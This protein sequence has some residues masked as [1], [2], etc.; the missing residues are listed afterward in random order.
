MA[1][2]SL[3]LVTASGILLTGVVAL[4]KVA[5]S[6]DGEGEFIAPAEIRA[7]KDAPGMRTKA[8]GDGSWA[9]IFSA[10][11]EV[12][13]GLTQWAA[14]Q[15]IHS[16]HLTA[17]GAWKSAILGYY[18]LQRKAYRKIAVNEQMELLS[19]IGDFAIDNGKPVLHAHVVL[20]ARDGS[21][22]GGHLIEGYT[23]PTM[24]VFVTTSD[25]ELLK[26]H[27]PAS[28]LDLIAIRK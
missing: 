22:R 10:G 28:G 18:G 2:R 12:F 27:D 6:A 26:T 3:V 11:D 21:T 24:E 13:S 8:L 5:M 4:Q 25:V 7:D 23:S 19:M 17:I 20:G 16:G 14:D 15:H 9:V 1:K